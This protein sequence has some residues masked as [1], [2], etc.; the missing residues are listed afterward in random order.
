MRCIPLPREH[1]IR[2]KADWETR[3]KTSGPLTHPPQGKILPNPSWEVSGSWETKKNKY[4]RD[5]K[6]KVTYGIHQPAMPFEEFSDLTGIMSTIPLHPERCVEEGR[7][8]SEP[9]GF[10]CVCAPK[11]QDNFFLNVAI[12]LVALV[13]ADGSNAWLL[14]LL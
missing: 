14:R 2:V 3:M 9:L 1:W 12:V 13:W 7:K 5:L 4:L 8:T 10:F 6:Y 11:L